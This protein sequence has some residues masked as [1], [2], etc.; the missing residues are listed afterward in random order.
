MCENERWTVTRLKFDQF[1]RVVLRG[2]EYKS[3]LATHA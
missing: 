2:L 3:E 1:A